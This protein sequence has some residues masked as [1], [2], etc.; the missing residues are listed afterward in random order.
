ME[1]L[2]TAL[3]VAGGG[4]AGSLAR[5]AASEWFR[6]RLGTR[7]PWGT[8]AVNLAGCLAIGCVLTLL[9]EKSPDDRPWRPL[10]VVGFLGGFT[11]FSAFGW[12]AAGLL[13]GRE[14]TRAAAYLLGSVAL[15]LLAVRAG[16]ALG[17]AT[18][19]SP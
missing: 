10:L 18:G 13:G 17:R 4:A 5:W 2:R 12:E 7:F 19:G 15:G 8:L 16:V 6:A 9:G 3:L 14:W 1:S 11:T